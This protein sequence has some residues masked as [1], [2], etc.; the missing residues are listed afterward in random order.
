VALSSEPDD[1][2]VRSLAVTYRAGH[3][4]GAHAHRWAQLIYARSGLMHVE[5]GDTLWF[6]PPTRAIWIPSGV[7]HAIC[8]RDDAALRTL[9]IAPGRERANRALGA[10]EVSPLLG[11]MILHILAIGMLDPA[12]ETHDRLAGVLMDLIDAASPLELA[13][14]MPADA[15]AVRLAAT[16]GA[17]PGARTELD[18]L[19]RQ[20]GGGLRTLQRLFARETG[21]SLD[22]WRQK[23][24]LVR[25]AS[26]LLNG[27]SVTEAA[28]ASGYDSPSAFIAAFRRQFGTTPGRLKKSG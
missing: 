10:L 19:A 18:A 7:A 25:A 2:D 22:A 20:A 1:F 17:D 5:A 4:I 12:L 3:R 27:E 21:L 16:I 9:Y 11:E 14:P 26:A 13:L 6:V 15:R 23:A 8:F 24:R 28:F